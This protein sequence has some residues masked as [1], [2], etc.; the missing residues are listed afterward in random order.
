MERYK[1]LIPFLFLHVEYKNHRTMGWFKAVV[2]LLLLEYAASSTM[3]LDHFGNLV[4]SGQ[5]FDEDSQLP[6]K[7][8][9]P[10]HISKYTVSY[11][12]CIYQ[13]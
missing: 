9:V 7:P 13:C 4:S 12:Q 6:E 8:Y 3:D 5:E 2:T 11:F 10:D 1:Q